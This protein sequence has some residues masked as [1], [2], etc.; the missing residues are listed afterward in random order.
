MDSGPKLL[1][2]TKLKGEGKGLRLAPYA[3][4]TGKGGTVG[5]AAQG[6]WQ[7]RIPGSRSMK[8]RG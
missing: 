4:Q 2:K 7:R 5:A 1:K 6:P 3:G 8:G